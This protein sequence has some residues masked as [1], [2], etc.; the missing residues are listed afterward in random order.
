MR[1][2]VCVCVVGGAGGGGGGGGGDIGFNDSTDFARQCCTLID[3]D[4]FLYSSETETPFQYRE[5]YET[6]CGSIP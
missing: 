5:C 2:C 1:A 3:K 4:T 6:W